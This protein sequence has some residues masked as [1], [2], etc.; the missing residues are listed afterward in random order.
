MVSRSLSLMVLL[1]LLVFAVQCVLAAENYCN[2]PNSWKEWH[3]LVQKYP[4]RSGRPGPP[5]AGN[6]AFRLFQS[7]RLDSSTYTDF[8]VDKN[9]LIR[10]ASLCNIRLIHPSN[11]ILLEGKNE[12]K[13]SKVA[14]V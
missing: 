9:N 4:S 11:P 6:W 13:F 2:D 12:G 7:P 8:L 5:D 10:Y 3:E 14:N 1:I